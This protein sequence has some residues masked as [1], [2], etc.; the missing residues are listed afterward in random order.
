MTRDGDLVSISFEVKPFCD[1]TVAI[2]RKDGQILRHL[3]SGVLGPNAPTPF[4]M[5]SLKQTLV[6]DGKDDQGRYV[7]DKDNTVVRVSLGLKARFERTLFWSPRKR[8]ARDRDL[9]WSQLATPAPEGV[10]V[11][12]SGFGDQLKLY[13][14]DGEYIRTIYPF[15]AKKLKDV[16]GLRMHRDS[17]PDRLLP[18]KWNRDMS[19]LLT[20]GWWSYGGEVWPDGRRGGGAS[21]DGNSRGDGA[22]AMALHGKRI[23]LGRVRLNRIATDGSSGGLPLYGPDIWFKQPGGYGRAGG[24][25][26]SVP[27]ALVRVDGKDF[28]AAV[29]S[30]MAFS[31]DGK[32]LYLTGYRWPPGTQSTKKALPGVARLAYDGSKHAECWVGDMA[33]E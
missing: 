20:M 33:P 5:E 27:G 13:D 11:Y 31:P 12:D 22:S 7:D 6:W 19:T 24:A 10:Y 3:A 17:K 30:S 18:L 4:R 16:V 2:E 9:L 21:A 8:P 23:A 25:K 1:A 28:H 14:H 26:P 15:P 29:P 32:W